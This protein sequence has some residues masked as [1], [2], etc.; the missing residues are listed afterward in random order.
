MLRLKVR[1]VAEAKGI[2][3]AL[4]LS[5]KTGIGYNSIYAIWNSEPRMI[6]IETLNRLCE[7]LRVRPGQLFVYT[8]DGNKTDQQKAW[9]PLLNEINEKTN[10]KITHKTLVA[11]LANKTDDIPRY[12][13]KLLKAGKEGKLDEYLSKHPVERYLKG[14]AA[15]QNPA[16]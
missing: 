15:H 5:Q 3:N 8:E 14:K 12:I 1:E 11:Y 16:Q 6:G 13:V 7:T 2:K 10:L 9:R 4:E